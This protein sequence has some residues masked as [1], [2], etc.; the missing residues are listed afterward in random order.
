MKLSLLGRRMQNINLTSGVRAHEHPA[1]GIYRNRDGPEAV[2]RAAANILVRHDINQRR[3][4]SGWLYRLS[5][6]ELDYAD[7]VSNCWLTIP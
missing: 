2:V 4:T 5:V 6:C 1:L 7:L 3:C